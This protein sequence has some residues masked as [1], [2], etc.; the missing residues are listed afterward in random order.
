MVGD[1]TVVKFLTLKKI[2][3]TLRFEH[4]YICITLNKFI[5]VYFALLAPHISF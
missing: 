2:T 3:E 1:K 5:M 4:I